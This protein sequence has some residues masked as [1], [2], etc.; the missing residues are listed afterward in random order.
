MRRGLLAERD[1][2]LHR[3]AV[4]ALQALDRIKPILELPKLRGVEIDPLGAFLHGA[5]Q[6]L[7]LRDGLP[8]QFLCAG[9]RGVHPL[10]RGEGPLDLREL[11]QHRVVRFAQEACDDAGLLNNALGIATR[12]GNRSPRAHRRRG[13]SFVEVISCTWCCKS[14]TRCSRSL[15]L[16]SSAALSC[17]ISRKAAKAV[18][19]AARCG[20]SLP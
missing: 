10:P 13:C 18:P 20:A 11:R 12:R 17:S 4:F 1:D 3:A 19:Q 15:S 6:L 5:E 14:A 2:A 9:D 7:Q 8:V 16:S